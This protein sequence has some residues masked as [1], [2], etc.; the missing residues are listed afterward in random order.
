[1]PFRER[2]TDVEQI[3]SS[4]IINQVL[5]TAL[6]LVSFVLLIPKKEELFIII[7]REKFLFLFILFSFITIV[8]SDYSFF[9]FKRIFRITAVVLTILSFL[10]YVQDSRE[11]V[12]T[13]KYIIYPY[14]FFT[15]VVVF[16]VPGAKDPQFHTWRGFT[17][18][19]NTLGQISLISTVLCFIF[20]KLEDSLLKKTIAAFMLLI[21]VVLLFGAYSSTSILTFLFLVGLSLILMMDII[22]KPLGIGRTISVATATTFFILF[23][24]LMIW[25]PELEKIIPALFGKDTTFSGRTDLWEYLFDEIKS[26][27]LLGTGYQAYWVPDNPR[28]MLLYKSFVWLPNQAHN[29]Y[30]DILLQTGVFGFLLVVFMIINYFV[31]FLKIRKPHPWVWLVVIS[32]ITNL[33]ESTFLRPAQFMNFM[34]MFSYLLLYMNFYREFSWQKGDGEE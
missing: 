19:K 7:K 21:A 1:M 28:V 24:G 13:F 15:L 4:N 25:L 31:N 10:L 2:I 11:I 14:L 9:T 5:Y 3:T 8:W 17:S 34:F 29:G 30:I 23:L 22:F 16:V 20:Y 6:F 27:P 12:K 32:L 18:H 26:H 33:Q